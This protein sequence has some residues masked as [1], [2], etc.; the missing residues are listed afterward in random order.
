MFLIDLDADLQSPAGHEQDLKVLVVDDSLVYHKLVSDALCYQPYTLLRAGNVQEALD[1]FARHS[2]PIVITDWM[3]PDLSGPDLCK[4][5]RSE[6][7]DRYTYIIM[8][9]SMC[10]TESLLRGLEAGADEFLTKPF[11]PAELQAR[12]GVG[13]R[14]VQLHREIDAKDRQ[15]EESSRFDPVT[16][17][18]NHRAIQEWATWQLMAAAQNGFPVWLVL[19]DVDGFGRMNEQ[20]GRE[21]G[22][23]VLRDFSRILKDSSL[24]ADIIGR[25]GD[26]EFICLITHVSQAHIAAAIERYRTRF[27]E[28]E[29]HFGGKIVKATAS[30]GAIG[31]EG[32]EAPSFA[33]LVLDAEASLN[34]AKT[35]GGNRSGAV[36]MLET[37]SGA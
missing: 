2:P 9:T 23:A 27:A 5:I 26:D 24:P 19:A 4:R 8:L 13:R 22:D 12:M 3:M 11:D 31:F 17:L 25:V 6:S 15:I 28:H 20:F 34:A 16:G 1:L 33:R 29:F 32:N 30:F 10:D 21:A 18:P 37:K 35:A 7:R 36:T 14:I